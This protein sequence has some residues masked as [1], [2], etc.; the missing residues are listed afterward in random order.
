MIP[1]R[2]SVIMLPEVPY[3]MLVRQLNAP[4]RPTKTVVS[5]DADSVGCAH[6]LVRFDFP[7]CNE[8]GIDKLD[9]IVQVASITLNRYDPPQ[10]YFF[11]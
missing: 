7:E 4:G 11:C 1:S 5:I 3:S 8:H 6:L 10:H 9:D 2:P